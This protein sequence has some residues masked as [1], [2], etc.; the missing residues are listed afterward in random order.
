LRKW[1]NHI[2]C[3]SRDR[4]GTIFCALYMI[5]NVYYSLEKL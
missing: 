2:R 5:K 1:L 3:E 4:E